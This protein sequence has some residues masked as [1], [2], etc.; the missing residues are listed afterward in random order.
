MMAKQNVEI[1]NG[2]KVK[3]I[4]THCPHCLKTL[5]NDYRQYGGVY[6]V[7]HH[8]QFVMELI[9]QGRIELDGT[10]DEKL[11]FHDPCY[12]GRYSRIFDEP[13]EVINRLGAEQVEMPRNRQ[14]SFCC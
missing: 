5:G 14:R 12:L 11:T 1:L 9:E 13:R 3:R 2:Y 4:V 7:V 6:E 8:S 10:L